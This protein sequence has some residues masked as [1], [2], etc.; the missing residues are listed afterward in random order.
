MENA[1]FFFLFNT[2]K[3]IR[4][5][6]TQSSDLH[7]TIQ[8]FLKT[9]HTIQEHAPYLARQV[10]TAQEKVWFTLCTIFIFV[11][12]REENNFQLI[13]VLRI[14]SYYQKFAFF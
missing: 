12:C 7:Q 10:F 11:F 1:R 4:C 5:L 9:M 6:L 2:S 14:N 8:T 3:N 13:Y